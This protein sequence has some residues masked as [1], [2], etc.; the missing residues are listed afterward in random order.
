MA[1]N[2][3]G[4]QNQMGKGKDRYN[5]HKYASKQRSKSVFYNAYP[6]QHS[7]HKINGVQRGVFQNIEFVP[8]LRCLHEKREHVQEIFD[9]DDDV[10]TM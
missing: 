5:G 1:S 7:N 10:I 3:F 9:W 8:A 2:K 4:H 6:H